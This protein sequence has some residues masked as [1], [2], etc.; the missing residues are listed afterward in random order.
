MIP[1]TKTK[2]PRVVPLTERA[3]TALVDWL[4]QRITWH[5]DTD[6]VWLAK[7]RGNVVDMSPNAV[8]LLFERLRVQ[9]GVRVS[10]HAFRRGTTVNLLRSGISG[11]SVERILGWSVGSPM[12]ANY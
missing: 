8:R 12:M 5:P 6:H 3:M 7:H 11:P 9:A 4:E 2:A 10:S 1:I